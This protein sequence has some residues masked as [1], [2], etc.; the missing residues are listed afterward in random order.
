MRLFKQDGLLHLYYELVNAHDIY[1]NKC[2]FFRL[3]ALQ[4]GLKKRFLL[5]NNNKNLRFCYYE[6]GLRIPG[7][8]SMIFIHGFSS[9][10]EAWL[11]LIE[12]S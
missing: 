7:Q 5:L 6:K 1:R 12:V 10:K 2:G 3:S 4:A 8:S 11:S 9:N